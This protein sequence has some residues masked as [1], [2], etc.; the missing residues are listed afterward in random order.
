MEELED[1]RKHIASAEQKAQ[2]EF[3]KTI[4]ALSGGGLGISFAFIDRFVKDEP[5]AHPS[6]LYWSWSLWTASLL[7][8]VLSYFCSIRALRRA[9]KQSYT[10]AAYSQRPGGRWAVATE[11]LN[12]L[13]AALFAAGL[14]LM[15]SFV[16]SNLPGLR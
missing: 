8:V 16:R 4:I 14:L 15:L 12:L 11:I 6:L 13:G 10:G 2:E 5:I 1:Y 7:L 3:D 9:L